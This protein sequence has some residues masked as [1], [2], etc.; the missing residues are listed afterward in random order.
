LAIVPWDLPGVG[1]SPLTVFLAAFGVS[2]LWEIYSRAWWRPPAL[3]IL[4]AT[5]LIGLTV[6]AALIYGARW[7]LTEQKKGAGTASSALKPK[8]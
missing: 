8:A 7:R 6:T 4:K 2:D 3:L 5:C 1:N